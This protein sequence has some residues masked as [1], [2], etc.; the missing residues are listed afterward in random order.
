MTCN[1]VT[2]AVRAST[3]TEADEPEA[4]AEP[5]QNAVAAVSLAGVSARE[6]MFY[7]RKVHGHARAVGASAAAALAPGSVCRTTICV[8]IDDQGVLNIENNPKYVAPP[9]PPPPPPPEVRA[10]AARE[11]D[12]AKQAVSI[13]RGSLKQFQAALATTTLAEGSDLE[14]FWAGI[15]TSL[16]TLDGR[17]AGIAEA[18]AAGHAFK[19]IAAEELSDLAEELMD[20]NTIDPS[21]RSYL[22][23][24]AASTHAA[25]L[26]ATRE[27]GALVSR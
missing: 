24:M 20:A 11:L 18:A 17:L 3:C 12:Q 6:R 16:S 19:P 5:T 22:N 9:P 27:G 8:R 1:A 23:E 26:T 7:L 2:E 4:L 25:L 10:L 15:G 14:A 21:S 13:L